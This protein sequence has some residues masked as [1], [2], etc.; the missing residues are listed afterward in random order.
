MGK[1]AGKVVIVTGSSGGI[2]QASAVGFAKEGAK[3]VLADINEA[4]MA[5]T[6]AMIK[7]LGAESLI[8][9]TNVADETA[10]Q[11]LVDQAVAKFG[12]LDVIFNNAGIAGHRSLI[13]DMPADQWRKVIDINLNGVFFCTKA[14]IPAMLENGGGVIV[15]T[16]SVEGLVGM[17]SL[18]HYGATKHAVLGL[19]K[20]TALEYGS[21]NIRCL[22][23]CPGFIDT[24]MTRNF[25]Q[26][27]EAEALAA[28]VPMKRAAQPEEIAHFV[29]WASSGEA[30]YMNGS[31]HVIDGALISGFAGK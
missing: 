18:S 9:P 12:K 26:E 19:T 10:C 21:Q 31:H 7:E 17:A 11:N 28:M 22:A 6:A 24:A 5:E 27:G 30:S 3:V 20:V 16:S 15:N 1:H 2:G 13:A 8:V 29:V 14:A 25:L 23:V 4:G